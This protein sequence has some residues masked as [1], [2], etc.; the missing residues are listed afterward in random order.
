[1]TT[2]QM[3]CFLLLAKNL[4]FTES[5][6]ELYISQPTLSRQIASME[7]ELNTKLF[8]RKKNRVYL[9]LT[10]EM[11]LEEL[12]DIYQ[13]Y[14]LLIRRIKSNTSNELTILKLGILEELLSPDSLRQALSD[15]VFHHSDVQIQ[16]IYQNFDDLID[17]LLNGSL[18]FIF[19][20]DTAL[21][22]ITGIEY[23]ILETRSPYLMLKSNHKLAV[24]SKI[25]L[26]EFPILLKDETFII[27]SPEV[28]KL[29]IEAFNREFH[30]VKYIPNY[31]FARSSNMLALW[32]A[33]GIG[34]SIVT[35]SHA[36]INHPDIRFIP[37]TSFPYVVDNAIAWKSRYENPWVKVFLQYL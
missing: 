19:T 26:S 29:T 30:K 10:G 35:D 5:A 22:S 8:T 34:I 13:D 7:A 27:M 6:D 9:T 14:Q 11:L 32:V 18:D 4:N 37:I 17:S 25:D 28:T 16:T 21:Y 31:R 12:K 2:D 20:P 3:K 15:F 33:A 23:K 1:M 36:Y 24:M